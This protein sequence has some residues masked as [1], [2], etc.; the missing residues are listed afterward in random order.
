MEEFAKG[1]SGLD[2]GLE[3]IKERSL[4]IDSTECQEIPHVRG[5]FVLHDLS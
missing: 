5:K 2:L 4:E 1:F 3:Y